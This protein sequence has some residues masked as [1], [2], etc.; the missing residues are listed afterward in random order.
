MKPAPTRVY[1]FTL[2]DAYPRWAYAR[3]YPKANTRTALVF[4]KRAQEEAP[5][6]FSHLQSDH[7]PEF[8]THFTEHGGIPHR[9]SRVR[10]PE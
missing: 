6:P 4:L 10:T 5:F 9:H 3:A 2:L 1:V 8:S 7:G